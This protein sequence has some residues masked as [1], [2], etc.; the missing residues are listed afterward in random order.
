MVNDTYGHPV[1]DDV[2]RQVA[3]RLT[4]NLRFSD[5]VGSRTSTKDQI[6]VSRLGGDEFMVLLPS[7][8][9]A[10]DAA[11][12]ARRLIDALHAP[13]EVGSDK[14]QLGISVGIALCPEDGD[15]PETMIRRSDQALSNAKSNLKGSFEFYNADLSAAEERRHIL[16]QALRRALDRD[17]FRMH[18]QPI[19]D[20]NTKELSG[21]EALIRWQSAELGTVNPDE[22]I[23]VAEES[24]LIVKI[25]EVVLRSVCEQIS[26]WR[27]RGLRVPAISVNLSAR[28]LIDLNLK[29]QVERVFRETGVS[30]P[31][32]QFELTE[33][34]TLAENPRSEIMLAW[35]QG[36]GTT[37]ALDDF[38]TG[39]ASLSL[40]RRI[41]FQKLKIDRSFVSGLGSEPEDERMV[42]GVI[43]LAHRLDIDTIA[44]GV[45]TEQQ[46]EVLRSEG[47]NYIQGYL[48][49]RPEAPEIFERLLEPMD[50]PGNQ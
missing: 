46:L 9:E 3:E 22:F 21:A 17:E 40:L 31:D 6:T 8:Q 4:S 28:Q 38:G 18:Y 29:D 25:G 19:R 24:G 15:S 37:L 36:L 26:Q 43:A 20:T 1:G 2:L 30:G 41:T 12:V 45:E 50:A 5:Q 44:E 34:S 32:I 48:F 7:I 14:L 13:F 16:E 27:K 35:L 23:P 49:G 47:C 42:R 10:G 39:Y 11:L 33:G